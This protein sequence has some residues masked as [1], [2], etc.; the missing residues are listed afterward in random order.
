VHR[1]R[2][3]LLRALL[4]P[5]TEHELFSPE[6]VDQLADRR[7]RRIAAILALHAVELETVAVAAEKGA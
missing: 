2:V 6:L 4:R 5:K 3:A 7:D 1:G